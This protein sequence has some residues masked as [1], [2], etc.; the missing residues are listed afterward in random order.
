[1]VFSQ[2][3]FTVSSPVK[4]ENFFRFYTQH[5]L[6]KNHLCSKVFR[7]FQLL[8]IHYYDY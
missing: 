5:F 6:F 1:M 3:V 2:S 8:N 4:S 7:F